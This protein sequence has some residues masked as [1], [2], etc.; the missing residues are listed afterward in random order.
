MT[1]T[2]ELDTTRRYLVPAA[3][4]ELPGQPDLVHLSL[5]EW[6]PQWGEWATG[7]ALCGWSTTQGA[8]PEGTTVTCPGCEA[9]RPQYQAVLDSQAAAADKR[10]QARRE[11]DEAGDTVENGAWH[12][13][14]LEGKWRWITS[15]MTTEQREYAADRVAAY[16]RYLATCDGDLEREEPE[17]LRWWR[18]DR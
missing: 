10:D 1:E 7:L 13:V 17:S 11:R 4:L 12:T 9:Y 8:L 3:R 6:L 18:D 5:Y 15:K 2:T 14:W 16:S